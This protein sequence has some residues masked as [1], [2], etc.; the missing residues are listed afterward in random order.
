M[1]SARSWYGTVRLIAG[2]EVRERITS[3]AF[4]I[5]TALLAII[6]LAAGIIAAIAGGDDSP[7]R[8]DVA[9]VGAASEGFEEGLATIAEGLDFEVRYVEASSRA[10]AE[11][12]LR[13]E[14]VD[15][16]ID[17]ADAADAEGAE[18]VS[19]KQPADTVLF[20][21]TTAWRTAS[22]DAAARLANLDEQQISAIVN[23]PIPS[24]VLLDDDEDDN[25]LGRGVGTAI[26][27]LLFI[28]INMFGSAVLT[29]V[30]EEKTTGVV[31][32]LLSQVTAHRL[33]AGKVFGMCCVAMVQLAVMIVAGVISLRVSGQTVPGEI[34]VALPTTIFW[35]V[36]GFVLYNTL[37]GLAGSFVSRVEDAQ[38]AAAPIS[39]L[40]LG[41]YVAVFAVGASPS[42]TTARVVSVLPPFS[43]LLMP[44]RIAAGTASVVEIAVAA[45][46]LVGAAYGMLRL[47]GSV[48]ART[49]LHRGTRL[50]WRELLALRRSG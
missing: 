47:A 35:F 27:V 24:L 21:I 39:L 8:Y 29:G 1:S 41:A 23:P 2:R 3:R 28:S 13:A 11:Q 42:S 12:M 40:F 5:T 18:I 38:S 4:V 48:Y 50:R 30:V 31:E 10:E 43:P 9:V 25:D 34:W 22:A 45:T 37:F 19:N 6:I 15:V 14:R 16:V 49:L 46:A 44:L 20:A 26:G 36:G 32:V 33:L 7:T 17:A